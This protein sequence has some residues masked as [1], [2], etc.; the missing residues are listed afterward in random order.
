MTKYAWL[1]AKN[2]YKGYFENDPLI[3]GLRKWMD[4]DDLYG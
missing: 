3:S 1:Y 4:W 2:E